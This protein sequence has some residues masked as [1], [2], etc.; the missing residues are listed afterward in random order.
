MEQIA[1]EIEA[2]D[3]DV[4]LL[5]EVDRNRLSSRQTDQP[6]YYAQRLGMQVSFAVNVRHR[7]NGQYGVATLSKYP[8]VGQSNTFLPNDPS[9][10]KAQQRGILNTKIKVGDTVISVYNTHLQHIYD[11]LRLRQMHVVARIVAADPLPKILGGDLNSGPRTPVLAAAR[12]VLRDSWDA[13]GVGSGNTVPAVDPK[14]RIDYVLYSD[15]LVPQDSQVYFSQV[16]D[17]RAVR[18]TFT[19]SDEDEPICVPVF[20]EPLE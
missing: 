19:L 17:H 10:P 13:V 8:I 16:S 9:L 20:D 5:Q 7:A 2:W 1:R 14:G 11:D 3:P 4:V 12:G 15:P 18:S 6:G